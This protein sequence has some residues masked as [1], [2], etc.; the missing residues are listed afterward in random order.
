VVLVGCL[1]VAGCVGQPAASDNTTRNADAK[2]VTLT[3]ASNSIVGGKNASGAQWITDYVIPQFTAMEKAKGVIVTVNFQ[4]DGSDDGSFRQKEILN[5]RTGGGGDIM[6]IDGTDVGNFSQ[7]G[8]IKPL[9]DVVGQGTVT[10]W[11][12]WKQIPQSVQ[13]LDQY[14]G[15]AYGI[16]IGTDGRV[17][18]FNKNLFAQAGLPANWQPNSW[19]DIISAGQALK[20]LP[21][22]TPVQ[23][24]GG[25][26]M[27]ETTTMNGFLPTLA[28]AG[29]LVY[30]NGKWQ[31]NTKAIRDSLGLYQQIY[32]SGLGDAT[33]QEEAK[34]RDESFAEFATGKIGI[35]AESDYFWRAVVS[36]TV[37]TDKMPDRNSTVGWAMIPAEKPGAGIGGQNFVSMSGGSVRVI[38][39][40]TQYP[41]QAWALLELMNSAQAVTVYE[42]KYLGGATQ[43]MSR[44]DVNN[45][46]LKDDPLMSFISQKV[47]PLTHFRP[48]EGAYVQ[49][50]TLV[51][52]ATA[53]VISGM[54]PDAAA[55]KYE[56]SLE[57]VVG[58]A[59]V[60]NN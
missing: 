4:G 6:E 38:N 42:Q 25:T 26:A 8:L 48:S 35:L 1:V 9:N 55:A 33:L 7:G 58:K 21:G 46:L 12:G 16:P 28:G 31:G 19:Q 45:N 11:E 23:L 51:Q 5:L 57:G 60:V 15:Q 17:L 3:I 44:S 43:L 18:F 10:A 2:N 53:D 14:N 50:S 56:K 54:S 47:L 27:T 41:Q 32:G 34:G 13:G 40:K 20:R 22:V 24:D 49:V 52:Q 36:P 29:A 59:N 39:P 37:G 30:G